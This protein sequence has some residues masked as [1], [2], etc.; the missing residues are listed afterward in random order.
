MTVFCGMPTRQYSSR[1]SWISVH[2]LSFTSCI[3]RFLVSRDS[4]VIGC[5]RL[6][7]VSVIKS[8]VASTFLL[9]WTGL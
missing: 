3:R 5:L 8:N 4:M 2:K 9:V 1:S 7:D 6:N